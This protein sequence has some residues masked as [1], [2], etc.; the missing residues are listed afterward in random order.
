MRLGG[1]HQEI[2]AKMPRGPILARWTFRKRLLVALIPPVFL[3]LVL[4]GYL[5]AWISNKYLSE[6]VNRALQIQTAALSRQFE[7]FFQDCQE[8]LQILA[9]ASISQENLASFAK[10]RKTKYGETAFIAADISKTIFIFK[11]K[12]GIIVV[13]PSKISL[14]H[15]GPLAMSD[16][17]RRLPKGEVLF[18]TPV[19]TTYPR[20][21]EGIRSSGLVM[22]IVRVATPCFDTNGHYKGFFLLSFDAGRLMDVLSEVRSPQSPL[23]GLSR[24]PSARWAYLLDENGWVCL[25]SAPVKSTA[26]AGTS[27]VKQGSSTP[28]GGT[29]AIYRPGGELKGYWKMVTDIRKGKPGTLE[30]PALEAARADSGPYMHSY[31]PIFLSDGSGEKKRVFG[32]VVLADRSDVTLWAKYAHINLI[33]VITLGS[34]IL[35]SLLIIALSRVIARPILNLAAAAE[36]IEKTGYLEE[37][38]ATQTDEETKILQTALNKMISTLKSQMEEIQKKDEKIKEQSKRER[39]RLEE[40]VEALKKRL[41]VHTIKEIIGAS[42]AIKAL[43]ADI[44][45]AASVNADVLIIGETG[46]GKQLAAEAIHRHSSRSD[47]PFISINCG[48]LDE[49][50][51]LD[52]LFGHVKGAFT[53]AK[54]DRKGAFV[55][56]DGGTL[57]LDEIGCA[58][59]RVQQSLLRVLSM[60]KI[61]PLGSDDEINVDVRL[62][63]ATNLNLKGLIEQGSFREDLYYRLE[64]LTIKTPSVRE[65]KEDIPL[66]IDHFLKQ[67][68]SLM[69][70]DIEGLSKG[71]VE[72]MMNYPWPGNVRELMNCL[73]RAVAMA[74]GSVIQA[75]DIKLGDERPTRL[76]KKYIISQDDQSSVSRPMAPFSDIPPGLNERQKKVF[77]FLM[78]NGKLNRLKYQEL[79]G[80]NLPSRTAL[81]DLQDLVKKGVLNKVGKGPA[82]WYYLAESGGG[83]HSNV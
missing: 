62:I 72:K 83:G 8:E 17:V 10:Y 12:N 23:F 30:L 51:L 52:T 75:E 18:S 39:A 67:A 54:V 82:T 28:D 47:K 37:I 1:F 34:T 78:E 22:D 48:A 25:S 33:L 45:R 42:P 7:L 44:S 14:I 73:T 61:K 4:T 40:E 31:A 74:E 13:P 60:R 79:A 46:S 3:I 63:A 69:N 6:E 41:Q 50:L 2:L 66:L 57:F 19:R 76:V 53:E 26:E 68:N 49:N 32:G 9:S 43:K 38:K 58:S 15:P 56:A 59:P 5:T 29:G 11:E 64:V 16:Q 55:A 36:K 27:D 35:I 70:K 24:S 81:Y 20:I 65:H 77:P 80:P 21:Q 71:A